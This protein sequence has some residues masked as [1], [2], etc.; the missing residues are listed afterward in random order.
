MRRFLAPILITTALSAVV[1]IAGPAFAGKPGGGST[2]DAKL[3]G[4]TVAS[5]GEMYTID[6][7]GFA[8]GS[9]VPLEI[10]EAN[11]CCIA[12]NLVADES[13]R[14]SYTGE[15]YAAGS[16]RVRAFVKRNTR[17]RV[18]AEWTFMAY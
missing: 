10:A 3:G 11:G 6:G 9:L 17:W 15:V 5:V 2:S 14:I 7:S 16:Y 13:G 12:L 8:P 4:P 1:A 18:A